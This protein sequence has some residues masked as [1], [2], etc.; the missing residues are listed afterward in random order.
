[1]DSSVLGGWMLRNREVLASPFGCTEHPFISE[2]SFVY[3]C[4]CIPQADVFDDQHCQTEFADHQQP[5]EV[6]ES[7]LVL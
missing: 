5:R 2:G 7:V 4:R 3:S 1:M 6:T